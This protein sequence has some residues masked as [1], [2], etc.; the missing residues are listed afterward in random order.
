MAT[1]PLR[2]GLVASIASIAWTAMSSTAAITFGVLSGSVVLVAFG[3]VGVFDMCGSIAL[4]LHF[5]HALRH[6]TFSERHELVA[7]RLVTLGLAI[8]GLATLTASILRLISPG[9]TSEP[10]GGLVV[11]AA[12]I[13][14]LGAL[15]TRKRRLGRT[16]PSAAL[17]ADGWLSLIGCGTATGTVLGLVLDR[18]LGWSW[19]DPTAAIGVAV[20]AIAVA[21]ANIKALR[22]PPGAHQ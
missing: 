17:I 4:V 5:R 10:V 16:I 13:V 6:E 1:S 21:I 20:A 12:S 18:T 8:V 2:D 19:S 22:T 11:A 9:H 14:A 15:G 7:L 3:S